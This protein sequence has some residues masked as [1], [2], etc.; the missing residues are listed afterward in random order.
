MGPV[1]FNLFISPL[2]KTS[3][4]PAYADNIYHISLGAVKDMMLTEIQGK[5]MATEK[6]MSGSGLKVNLVKTE[7]VIFHSLNT[8]TGV[9][10]IRNI[11]IT[12][13]SE[14]NVWGIVFDNHL[15]WDRQ[16]DKAICETRKA[17]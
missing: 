15:Q 7:M 16:V 9:L 11:Q 4:D 13:S 10:G 1:L 14:M 6:W 8:S 2:L 3:S 12:S 5:I 17:A